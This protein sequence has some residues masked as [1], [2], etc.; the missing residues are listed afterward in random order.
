M[1]GGVMTMTV[2]TLPL[3]TSPIKRGAWLLETIFNRPPSEPKVAFAIEDDAKEAELKQSV[4]E[5]FEAHRNQA[6]CYSCHV[7]LDPPG[8][9]LEHYDAMGQWRDADGSTPVDARADWNGEAFDGRAAFKS[10]IS[11]SL[12]SSPVD[13]SSTS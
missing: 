9:A 8:F 11:D 3:R 10:L 13:S 6:A 5:R 1:R 2:T 7:L 12:T 4:S